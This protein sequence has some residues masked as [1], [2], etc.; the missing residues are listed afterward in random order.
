[1]RGFIFIQQKGK[2]THILRMDKHSEW[3]CRD[4]ACHVKNIAQPKHHTSDII[5]RIP[6]FPQIQNPL[7]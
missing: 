5:Q 6:D 4:V 3:L 7:H 1:M 2:H